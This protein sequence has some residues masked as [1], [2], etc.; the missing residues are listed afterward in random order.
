MRSSQTVQARIPPRCGQD[1]GGRRQRAARALPRAAATG[2]DPATA[3]VRPTPAPRK[4]AQL[5]DFQDHRATQG[6]GRRH[7]GRSSRLRSSSTAPTRRRPMTPAQLHAP[8]QPRRHDQYHHR[9][10]AASAIGF[11]EQRGDLLQVT[12]MR[13]AGH[14]HRPERAGTAAAPRHRLSQIWFKLGE[15]LILSVTA[16]LVFL[17]VVRPMIARLTAPQGHSAAGSGA[18]QPTATGETRNA[19]TAANAAGANPGVPAPAGKPPM[20]RLTRSRHPAKA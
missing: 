10:G 1:R 13:F 3:P 17:L 7:R 18:A 15:I 6:P 8:A 9:A 11:N 5:R 4:P 16:L 14:R 20:G 19:T 2:H 12:N